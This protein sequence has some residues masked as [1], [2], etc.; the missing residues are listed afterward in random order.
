MLREIHRY[1]WLS[2]WIMGRGLKKRND[3]QNNMDFN[4][5]YPGLDIINKKKHVLADNIT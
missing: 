4:I 3:G 2:N 1:I 5:D